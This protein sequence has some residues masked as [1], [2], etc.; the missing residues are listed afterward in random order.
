MEEQFNPYPSLEDPDFDRKIFQK[1]EFNLSTV[2]DETPSVPIKELQNALCQF[3]LSPNQQFLSNY[4]NPKTPYNGILLYHGTGVGKTCSS[5]TIA[6]GFLRQAIEMPIYILLNPSIKASFRKNIFDV[7]KL[8]DNKPQCTGMKYMEDLEMVGTKEFDLLD[9]NVKKLIRSRY[10][11]LGYIEF[12]NMFSKIKRKIEQNFTE[13]LVDSVFLKEIKAK[14][15]NCVIII[16]EVH[17][18]KEGGKKEGK[19]VLQALKFILANTVNLRLILL[20]AT[21]MFNEASEIVD[22]INLLRLNDKRP[23]LKK[24]DIFTKKGQFKS[25]DSIKLFTSGSRG[26]I[27]YLRGEHPGKFPKRLYPDSVPTEEFLLKPAAFP[28]NDIFGKRI[29]EKERIKDL[30]IVGVPMIEDQEQNYLAMDI[31][32]EED[33]TSEGQ[34]SFNIVGM[35]V[36]NMV[37]PNLDKKAKPSENIGAVGLERIVSRERKKFSFKSEEDKRVFELGNIQ[38]F[39]AKIAKIVSDIARSEGIVFIYS[40]FISSGVIPLAL[41]LEMNGYCKYGGSLIKGK[42]KQEGDFQYILITGDKDLTGNAYEDYIKIENENKN[43]E[44]V[45]VIIGSESAAEGLDF[46]FIREVHVMDPWYH[47]NKIEQVIGRAIRNCSHRD[48]PAKKRN[49]LVYLYA[50][51]LAGSDTETID[52]R[53][54]RI[55]ERKMKNVSEVEY[56]I[57]RNAVDCNLTLYSNRFISDYWKTPQRMITSKGNEIEVTLNDKDGSKMCN[58]KSC[59]YTCVP[60]LREDSTINTNTFSFRG[61]PNNV[62]VIIEKI[63]KLFL[64]HVVL[65]ETNILKMTKTPLKHQ[66]LLLYVLNLIVSKK[67]PIN[68]R[69]VLRK[70]GKK[71]RFVPFYLKSEYSTLNNSRRKTRKRT[72]TLKLN[73]FKF[74]IINNE[75]EEEVDIANILKSVDKYNTQFSNNLNNNVRKG[76]INQNDANDLL[77]SRDLL[78]YGV[79]YLPQQ[80]KKVL[81]DYLLLKKSL[82]ESEQGILELL[83]YYR[84]SKSKE[85]FEGY[86]LGFNGKVEYFKLESGKIIK[87]TPAEIKGAR[88]YIMRVMDR[89]EVPAKIIGF[90][91][92][93]KGDKEIVFKIRDKRSEGRKKTQKKTGSICRNQ[94]MLK[95]KVIDIIQATNNTI[96]KYTGLTKKQIPS[97][98]NLCN[99]LEVVFR[100]FDLKRHNGNR[101]F[102]TY[103][104][105]IERKIII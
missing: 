97:K 69:G 29:P 51:I 63:Q 6:E 76:K 1:K 67:V 103:E 80:D 35:Q 12:A 26:Y 62:R 84:C 38:S 46:R 75:P 58:F 74:N 17:N 70:T 95:G 34:G 27:S 47:F 54:Y 8:R 31:P 57:K 53:M 96:T 59:N 104:E 44:R 11:F 94:G 88:K 15:S 16:D 99:D 7:T 49:V 60:D 55:C 72:D 61:V 93:N 83:K 10:N 32:D 68:D 64:T 40:R 87:P 20:S 9:K 66:D 91:D 56:I 5:I 23:L 28:V 100:K 90:L 92:E 19:I 48:L 102:Y 85:G 77:S 79:Q 101:W 21:P 3:N 4:I 82:T 39:S 14:F 45:K 65:T 71:Y 78:S 18:I 81:L 36:S 2:E 24:K 42:R 86:K 52:Q 73:K 89:E 22:L 50:A 43:G 41:A 37:F 98:N 105:A 13:D 30:K 33:G 25:M